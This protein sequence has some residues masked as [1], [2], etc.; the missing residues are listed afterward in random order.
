MSIRRISAG[1]RLAGWWRS[2]CTMP[3]RNG[4]GRSILADSF[5]DHPDGQTIY[6]RSVAGSATCAPSPKAVPTCCWRSR[7]TPQSEAKSSRRWRASIPRLIVVGAEAVWLANQRERAHAI[8]VPTLVLCGTDDKPTPPPL[9]QALS[10][11]I[12]GAQ[13]RAHRARRPL[14]KHRA[15][16]DVQ[17]ARQCLHP[18]RRFTQLAP[19]PTALAPA[20]SFAF[21]AAFNSRISASTL[22]VSSGRKVMSCRAPR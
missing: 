6:D 10:R 11:L 4:C 20:H 16:G 18:R 17:H 8:R 14:G 9:S 19:H 15:T 2:P 5:A 7:R 12:P 3:G 1:C 13:I 22:R 21:S